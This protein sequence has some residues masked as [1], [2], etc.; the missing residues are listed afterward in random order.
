M[1]SGRARIGV[2]VG[3]AVP[4]AGSTVRPSLSPGTIPDAS[5]GEVFPPSTA[6]S[7]PADTI[8]TGPISQSWY[9]WPERSVGSPAVVTTSWRRDGANT[10]TAAPPTVVR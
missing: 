9:T 10:T 8:F 3:W 1:G 2:V 4:G 6:G 7:R 5:T